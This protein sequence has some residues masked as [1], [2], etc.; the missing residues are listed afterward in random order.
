M[1][2]TVRVFDPTG[3]EITRERAVGVATLA[4]AMSAAYL[5]N[6]RTGGCCDVYGPAGQLVCSTDQREM[7]KRKG[8]PG[9]RQEETDDLVL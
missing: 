5:A 2:Y 9:P 4:L 3:S 6:R 8:T 1:S 7:P